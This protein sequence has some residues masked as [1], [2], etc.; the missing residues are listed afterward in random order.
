MQ[1]AVLV[2]ITLPGESLAADKADERSLSSVRPHVFGKV[3]FLSAALAA[4]LAGEGSLSSVD[5]SMFCEVTLLCEALAAD[6][7]DEGAL[8]SVQPDMTGEMTLPS[9]SL[10][11]RETLKAH[12]ACTFRPFTIRASNSRSNSPR[13]T[14]SRAGPGRCCCWTC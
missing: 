14:S 3:A 8:S 13:K 4:D 6:L 7:A 11:A 9:E 2:E 5:P 1:P 12:C 10:A